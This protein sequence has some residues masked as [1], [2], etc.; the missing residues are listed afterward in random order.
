MNEPITKT[1]LAE[2]DNLMGS[3][4]A[5]IVVCKEALIDLEKQRVHI[6]QYEGPLIRT[7]DDLKSLYC[8][9]RDAVLRAYGQSVSVFLNKMRSRKPEF[10]IPR[11]MIAGMLVER[12]H[13]NPPDL[14]PLMG[15]DRTTIMHSHETHLQLTAFNKGYRAQLTKAERYLAQ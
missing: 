5:M 3:Y 11:H 15:K 4:K 2:I 9:V 7:D 8:Q 1:R 6:A 12:F 13:V 14:A 10:C